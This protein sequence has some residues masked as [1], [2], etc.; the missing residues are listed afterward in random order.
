MIEHSSEYPSDL[1][2]FIEEIAGIWQPTDI[3][4]M[5]IANTDNGYKLLEIGP[6][7][8]AG[9]YLA[10]LRVLFEKMAEIALSDS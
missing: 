9:I 1:H 8:A 4:C 5:D 3:Y 10:N 6:A 7:N 2:G